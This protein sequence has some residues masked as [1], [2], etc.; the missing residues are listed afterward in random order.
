MPLAVSISLPGVYTQSDESS[1]A[2]VL[3][4]VPPPAADYGCTG[5]VSGCDHRMAAAILLV[6]QRPAAATG[7][8]ALGLSRRPRDIHN[9]L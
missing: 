3:A 6:L 4:R 1:P 5:S 7:G 9:A 8:V 2:S